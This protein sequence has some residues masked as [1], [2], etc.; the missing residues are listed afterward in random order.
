[1]I[2]ETV[3]ASVDPVTGEEY[4]S[5]EA[6]DQL[7]AIIRRGGHSDH[8]SST[9]VVQF[10]AWTPA[11]LSAALRRSSASSRIPFATRRSHRQLLVRDVAGELDGGAGDG[12]ERAEAIR[13][14]LQQP[15][16]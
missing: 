9:R 1:M 5:P 3:P 16:R 7:Q 4:F 2:I 6:V 11:A 15:R 10:A 13:Q 12:L 8:E 14:H